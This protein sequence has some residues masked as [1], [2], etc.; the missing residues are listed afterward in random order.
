LK[1]DCL[2]LTDM[3]FLNKIYFCF[4]QAVANFKSKEVVSIPFFLLSSFWKLDCSKYFSALVNVEKAIFGLPF[5]N[6]ILL[7]AN[8]L[9]ENKRR[10]SAFLLGLVFNKI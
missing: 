1:E 5:S 2:E 10:I 7:E 3:H 4:R 6:K 9:S 8:L